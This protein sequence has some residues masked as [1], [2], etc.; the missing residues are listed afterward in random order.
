MVE[1]AIRHLLEAGEPV[2]YESVARLV[3]TGKLDQRTAVQDVLIP[4]VDLGL[5]DRLLHQEVRP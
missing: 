1:S 4:A 5:Y 2:S 3:K